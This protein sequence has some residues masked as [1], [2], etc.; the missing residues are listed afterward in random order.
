[1]DYIEYYR[2][3][4]I[5]SNIVFGLRDFLMIKLVDTRILPIVKKLISNSLH[6]TIKSRKKIITHNSTTIKH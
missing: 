5:F 6:Q 1:M 4:N 3:N 2:S